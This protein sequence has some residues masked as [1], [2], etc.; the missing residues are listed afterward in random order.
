M[1]LV[2]GVSGGL[3]GLILNGLKAIDDGDVTGGTR[4]G[5]GATAR[6]IDFDDPAS[7]SEGFKD[8]DVL[9]FVSAGYAE[10]DVVLARHGAVVDAAT[11]AGVKHVIY[12]SLASS[13]ERMTIALPHRWTEAR[14]AEA[15]FDVTV[16]RNALYTE[17]P[18]GLAVAGAAMA[19]ETGVFAA[20]FGDGRVSV[21]AK[22]DLA[23][24]AVRVAAETDRDLA[25]GERSR[26]ADRT[27]ELEGLTPVGGAE[28]ADAL[29]EAL[30]RPV[31]YHPV[32]LADAR[33]GLEGSGF[34]PYQVTHTLSILSNIKAGW[35]EANRSDLTSLL[36][37]EPSPVGESIAAVVKAGLSSAN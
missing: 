23:A 28:L 1:I 2:T 29:A 25:A 35:T 36:E 33:A 19:A 30:G 7:L 31:G 34:L 27:Y 21:V 10:D 37:T 20:P 15:P 8:V 32:S 12:T 13:G 17:I 26:H 6:R 22:E 4:G 5:D 9:V 24:V 3:G 16:L 14:L 18:A 11:A